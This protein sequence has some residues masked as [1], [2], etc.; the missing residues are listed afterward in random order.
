MKKNIYIAIPVLL[1]AAL[2]CSREQLSPDRMAEKIIF[3]AN[4]SLQQTKAAF[5]TTS[6]FGVTAFHSQGTD[7]YQYFKNVQVAYS[8]GSWNPATTLYWPK[9]A[10]GDGTALEFRAYSPYGATPWCSFSDNTTLSGEFSFEPASTPDLMYADPVSRDCS[11]AGTVGLTFNHALGQLTISFGVDRFDDSVEKGEIEV[12]GQKMQIYCKYPENNPGRDIEEKSFVF[13]SG[14]YPSGYAAPDTY[15]AAEQAF[16][17]KNPIQNIWFVSVSNL[18]IDNLAW[19]G[20]L[21]MTTNGSVWTKPSNSVWTS[22]GDRQTLEVLPGDFYFSPNTK[23]FPMP[24]GTYSILPQDLQPV[25]SSQK[26]VISMDVSFKL[27]RAEDNAA[28]DS[29]TTGDIRSQIFDYRDIAQYI[30]VGNNLVDGDTRKSGAFKKWAYVTDHHVFP[31]GIALDFG[32]AVLRADV[33]PLLEVTKTVSTPLYDS[34]TSSLRY[35]KMNT[36]TSYTIKVDPAGDEITFSPT[37][38]SWTELSK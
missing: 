20:A 26:P 30:D 33:T 34:K 16:D 37:I 24:F 25:L 29:A 14:N 12:F 3:D 2:A 28:N 21:E 15:T 10:S 6:D 4:T 9:A 27:F 17:L 1:A 19:S 22:P 8:G 23:G 13:L 5:P 11:S 35:L 38:D 7:S 36:N 31:N 18:R 32:K